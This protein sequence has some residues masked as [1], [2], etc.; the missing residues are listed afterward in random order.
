ML[1]GGLWAAAIPEFSGRTAIRSGLRSSDNLL[2]NA[3]PNSPAIHENSH[4]TSPHNNPAQ[5]ESGISSPNRPEG[6][7][8]AQNFPTK[9]EPQP[10]VTQPVPRPEPQSAQPQP[11]PAYQTSPQ[12]LQDAIGEPNAQLATQRPVEPVQAPESPLQPIQRQLDEQM[13]EPPRQEVLS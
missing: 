5:K 2:R 9:T 13:L 6:M 10:V 3:E 1:Q 12:T 4:I 7:N 8:E 11:E